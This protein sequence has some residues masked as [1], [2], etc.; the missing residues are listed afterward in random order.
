M[1]TGSMHGAGADV[2]AVWGYV[3][4]HAQEGTV[5]LN[6]A[7]LAPILGMSADAVQTAIDLLCSPDPRSRSALHEG[8]RLLSVGRFAFTVPTHDLYRSLRTADDRRDYMRGYMAERRKD[9][10]KSTRVNS[11]RKLVSPTEAES[12]TDT[13][14]KTTT[15]ART[16][17]PAW[18]SVVCDVYERHYGAGSFPY[19]QAGKVLKPLRDAGYSAEEIAARFDRY[20]SRLDDI[21]YLSLPKFR[22]TFGAYAQDGPTPKAQHGGVAQR[23]FEA[24][25]KALAD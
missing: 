7:H 20:A 14:A 4:S 13:K 23:T 21:R 6:P 25:V 9:E 10:K 8:R 16:A 2:F 11:S 15:T 3:I 19:G 17:P 24:G 18:L 5:E 22:Q 1:Y 12:D